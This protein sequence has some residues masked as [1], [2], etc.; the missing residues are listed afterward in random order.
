MRDLI[1]RILVEEFSKIRVRKYN[2][3]KDFNSIYE[4]LS[5]V[6]HIV[7]MTNDEILKEIEPIDIE[8]SIIIEVDG[9]LAGF[10]FLR[11]KDIPEKINPEIYNTIKDLRGVEGVAL[12]VFPEYKNLGIGKKL[13]EYPQQMGYD[14]IWGYQYESLKNLR[15][16]LKRRKY[17]GFD[18]DENAHITYQVF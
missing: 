6:Y 16:W 2:P 1:K 4:N 11:P 17:F 3:F 14:Y 13:I 12:G 18:D 9:K 5:N 15:D 10:Y 8:N 7:G